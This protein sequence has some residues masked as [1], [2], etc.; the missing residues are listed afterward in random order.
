MLLY[1]HIAEQLLPVNW[2]FVTLSMPMPFL[3]PNDSRMEDT[4]GG[5][6]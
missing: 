3:M 4:M 1:C 2:S 5:E 6:C